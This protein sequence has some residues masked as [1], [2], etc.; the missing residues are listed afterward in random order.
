MTAQILAEPIYDCPGPALDSGDIE[1]LRFRALLGEAEWAKLPLPIRQRFSKHLGG[2]NTVV[3]V[4]H[5]LETWMSRAGWLLAQTARLIGGPLPISRDANVASMVSVTEDLATGGQIWTRLY[6][7]RSHF[8]Q[9]IHSS[10]QFA[11]PTGLE[12]HIGRG[13]GM[14]LRVSVAD[15]VLVFRSDHYFMTLRGWR[16]PLPVWLC[17]GTLT[18]SHAELG[19]GRFRFTL[20]V[21]HPRFGV[22][23]RQAAAFREAQP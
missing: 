5:V 14:A 15:S 23:I 6:A 22:L 18:V 3:Y 16:I 20:E 21:V 11:G 8:P 19:N 1:D 17:P 12:E 10:K 2:G 7:R 13:I 4:G 9:V